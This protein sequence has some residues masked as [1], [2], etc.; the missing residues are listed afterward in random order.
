MNAAEYKDKVFFD[1][2][3]YDEHTKTFLEKGEFSVLKVAPN[4]NFTCVRVSD[5]S[6]HVEFDMAHVIRGIR[7]YEEEL[8]G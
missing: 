6:E 8:F 3:G 1:A 2:G 5:P 7:K 4:N